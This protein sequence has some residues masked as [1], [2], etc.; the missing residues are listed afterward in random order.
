ML[1]ELM[2]RAVV[3]NETETLWHRRPGI[4]LVV[5]ISQRCQLHPMKSKNR[6]VIACHHPRAQLQESK[7]NYGREH[8]RRP[9]ERRP[10][11]TRH[12]SR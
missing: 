7:H 8:D 12:E 11:I 3:S 2:N 5:T 6:N 1:L 9:Q 10:S 4:F